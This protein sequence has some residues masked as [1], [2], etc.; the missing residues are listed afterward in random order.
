MDI[1]DSTPLVTFLTNIIN[2]RRCLPS[3]LAAELG[4]CHS[5]LYRWLHKQTAPGV[6][7]CRKLSEYTGIPLQAVLSRI[8]Y[9]PPFTDS[10]PNSWP[11]FREYVSKKYPTELDDDLVTLIENLITRR[12]DRIQ[13]AKATNKKAIKPKLSNSNHKKLTH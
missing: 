5:T 7:S 12:R 6:N 4:V 2:Q 8:G 13:H 9:I 1:E 3:Q 10:Q 11:E